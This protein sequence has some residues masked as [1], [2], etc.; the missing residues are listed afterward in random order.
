MTET[1]NNNRSDKFG[2]AMG[3]LKGIPGVISTTP[4]T[5]RAIT[6]IVGTPQTF[7][8]QT[9]RRLKD[10]DGGGDEIGDTLFIEFVDDDGVTRI[11][12]PPAITKVIARQ[13]DALG[14]RSRKRAAQAGY[15]TRKAKGTQPTLSPH[16]KRKAVRS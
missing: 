7:I 12:C 8:V 2:R 5:V 13:R 14:T 6:P 4:T 9:F 3:S 10:P 11:A 16:V 1:N 15:E